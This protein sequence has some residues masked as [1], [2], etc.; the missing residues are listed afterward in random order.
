[1]STRPPLA[2]IRIADFSLYLP[3]PYATRLLCDLGA[4]VVKVEPLG[5]DPIREFLPGVYEFL[6]RGK[7]VLPLDLKSEAGL[8][9]AHQLIAA[10]DVVLE[11]FRPGVAG[12]LGIGFEASAELRAGLVYCSLSGYGQTGPER[13]RPGHDIG[14]EAGG[15]A[16]AGVLAIGDPPAPPHVAV[17]D[18]GGAM[19]AALSICA[20]LVGRGAGGGEPTRIDVSMQEAVTHLSATRWGRYLR[21]R[22]EPQLEDLANYA[23]GAGFFETA[24]GRF[25]AL[26]SVEDKFWAGL[27]RALE[28]DDLAAV[29][30]DTHAGR[31]AERSLLRGELATAIAVLSVDDLERRLAAEDV[32]VD[33]V[34]T[35]AEVCSD[36]HLLERGI[37]RALDDG[38][39]LDFPALIGGTRPGAPQPTTE[40]A[41]P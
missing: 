27:C 37:L 41:T 2:G 3:G 13:D 6:N 40:G 39:H 24:D 18:L 31:M 26:A 15:G 20:A 12:R 17:G 29:P 28:R 33:R 7:R 9:A 21:D 10:T 23:P 32:P 4:E 14:Y 25:V 19:F 36:P 16:Y 5:G 1:M 30:H 22:V 38:L 35:A 8:D 11:G 34:R